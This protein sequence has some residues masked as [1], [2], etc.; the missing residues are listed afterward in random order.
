MSFPDVILFC[1]VEVFIEPQD[2]NGILDRVGRI[3]THNLDVLVDVE[4]VATRTM[5]WRMSILFIATSLNKRTE[6]RTAVSTNGWTRNSRIQSLGWWAGKKK[7][8]SSFLQLLSAVLL[9]LL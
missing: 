7:D 6:H 4:R 2:K 8:H 9:G 5:L 3:L 1:D